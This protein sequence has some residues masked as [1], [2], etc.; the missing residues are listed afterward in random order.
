MWPETL[1]GHSLGQGLANFWGERVL[2]FGND[3]IAKFVGC[4]ASRGSCTDLGL[5]GEASCPVCCMTTGE[6]QSLLPGFVESLCHAAPQ[7]WA[8][9]STLPWQAVN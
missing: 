5:G 7:V 1:E 9:G 8:G 3:V 4:Q 2:M 6:R